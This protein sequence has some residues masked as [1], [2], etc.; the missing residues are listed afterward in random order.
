MS[1]VET[2]M[3]FIQKLLP[4]KYPHKHLYAKNFRPNKLHPKRIWA[5]FNKIAGIVFRVG[6]TLEFGVVLLVGSLLYFYV[7]PDHLMLI[8]EGALESCPDH[9]PEVTRN[10]LLGLA[11]A[12]G[13]YGLILATHRQKDFSR[14]VYQGEIQFFSDQ[15]D[16]AV[17]QLTHSNI[18]KRSAGVRILENMIH[19]VNPEQR[20]QIANTLRDFLEFSTTISDDDIN[21]NREPSPRKQRLDHELAINALIKIQNKYVVYDE[22]EKIRFYKLDLRGFHFENIELLPFR[23]FFDHCNMANCVFKNIKVSD[24]IPDD[25]RTA[26]IGLGGRSIFQYTNL[27]NA[28]FSRC[29]FKYAAFSKC[30]FSKSIF[31][32]C[33]IKV[34]ITDCDLSD[35]EFKRCDLSALHLGIHFGI[36]LGEP[37]S[38]RLSSLENCDI[39]N[40]HF[41]Y[42]GIARKDQDKID[43]AFYEHDQKPTIFDI[44]ANVKI[45]SDKF[46]SDYRGYKW[47][48][49]ANGNKRR[50]FVKLDNEE[51]SEQPIQPFPWDDK[52]PRFPFDDTDD[53]L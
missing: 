13:A 31:T 12:G 4:D 26:I 9:D 10:L 6:F 51:Y 20:L 38:V 46:L 44:K 21:D 33:R 42:F 7:F 39:S 45:D 27:Q 15:F 25:P 47:G 48:K 22:K 40:T 1:F 5:N 50:F 29:S 17:D 35:V 36:D 8:C 2:L 52:N 41:Y 28:N 14:Q 53:L 30:N 32:L 18:T 23:L 24:Y 3:N 34:V 11:G 19:R 49:D 16:S 37:K 43:Q